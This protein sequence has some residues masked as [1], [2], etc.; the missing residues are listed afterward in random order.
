MRFQILKKHVIILILFTILIPINLSAYAEK[1]YSMEIDD[2]FFNIEYNFDG[3]VIAMEIDKELNSL[4]IG[5]ENVK[6][7]QFEITLPIRLISAENNEFAILVNGVEV[8]YQVVET[9][10][11]NLTFFVPTYTEEIEI[12][13]TH[14]IPEFPLGGVL[15]LSFIMVV[16]VLSRKSKKIFFR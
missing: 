13:G 12:I 15:T 11:V 5:T 3:D 14:V 4:L 1:N 9:S 7:S 8:V 6:D 10:D 2:D 16:L